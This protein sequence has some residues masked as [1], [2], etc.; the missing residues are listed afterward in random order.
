LDLK[1][2]DSIFDQAC[3]MGLNFSHLSELVD[4]TPGARRKPRF[5]YFS[6]SVRLRAEGFFFSGL[7]ELG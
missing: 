5:L 1:L 7:S 6:L 2:D 3:D 4:D